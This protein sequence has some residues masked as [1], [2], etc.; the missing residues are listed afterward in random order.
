[1]EINFNSLIAEVK[2]QS[3]IVNIVSARGISVS[4]SGSRYKALCPF[5]K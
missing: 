5:H 4:Q 2:T 1:M 3:S